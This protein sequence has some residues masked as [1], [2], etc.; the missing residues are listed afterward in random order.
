MIIFASPDEVNRI[1]NEC[2]KKEGCDGCVFAAF[3]CPCMCIG[4]KD[5]WD[6]LDDN[7]TVDGEKTLVWKLIDE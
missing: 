6:E 5:M 3:N 7:L 1:Y 4:Y 2:W